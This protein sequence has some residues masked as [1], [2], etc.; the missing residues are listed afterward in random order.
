MQNFSARIR[1]LVQVGIFVSLFVLT[2]GT[3]LAV[4][5]PSD[6]GAQNNATDQAEQVRQ[7]AKTRL[8]EAKLRACQTREDA[9]KKRASRLAQLATNME[10][11]FDNHAQRV[12]EYYTLKV[13]QSGKTV[14]NYESLVADI[15]AKKAAVAAALSAAQNTANNFSC[16]GDDPKGQLTQFRKDMQA[17]KKALKDYRTSIKNLIVAVRSVVGTTER[18]TK[19]SPK[20]TSSP[21]GNE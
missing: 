19:G 3:V 5:K 12:E 13:V 8:T 18:D 9:I 20:P 21:G 7:Q 1:Y 17:V 10:G 15:D 14:A 6:V 4:G 11:K 16:T 2:V